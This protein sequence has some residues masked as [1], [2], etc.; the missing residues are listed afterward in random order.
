VPLTVDVEPALNLSPATAAFGTV[1][2]GL[3][4]ERRVI[5]RGPT[6]FRVTEIRGTDDQVTVA[7]GR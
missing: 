1:A 2:P 6:A 4:T 7:T 5:L 3:P